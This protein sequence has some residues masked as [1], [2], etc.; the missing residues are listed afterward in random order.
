MSQTINDHQYWETAKKSFLF[1]YRGLLSQSYR[2]NHMEKAAILSTLNESGV[3]QAFPDFSLTSNSPPQSSCKIR[4]K[5]YDGVWDSVDFSVCVPPVFRKP[6]LPYQMAV[7][8]RFLRYIGE[9]DGTLAEIETSYRNATTLNV[10]RLPKY[11]LHQ[12]T[13]GCCK[14]RLGLS[15]RWHKLIERE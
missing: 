13:L 4:D 11:L 7:A 15:I 5:L 9:T 1:G 3:T 8:K 12:A 14:A 10:V 6:L 2:Q